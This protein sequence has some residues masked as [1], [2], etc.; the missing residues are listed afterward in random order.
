M[1]S[2]YQMALAMMEMQTEIMAEKPKY[3]MDF[4]EC[5]AN[6]YKYDYEEKLMIFAQKP[7]ATACASLE[8]WN[9]LGRWVNRGAKGI[10]LLDDRN[11]RYRLRYV[12]DVSD[13]NSRYGYEIHLWQMQQNYEQSVIGAMEN[14]FGE[15][16]RTE[17]TEVALLELSD[18]V[19][20]DNLTDYFD[21]IEALSPGIFDDENVKNE[22]TNLVVNS[23]TYMVWKRCG[24]D[25]SKIFTED[26]FENSI[27]HLNKQTLSVIGEASSDISRTILLEIGEAV[28]EAARDEAQNRTFEKEK[29]IDD[30]I[31][32]KYNSERRIEHGT[33]LQ[34]G[35]RDSNPGYGSTGESENREVRNDEVPLPPREQTPDVHNDDDRGQA[36]RASGTDRPGSDRDDGT[37][38]EADGGERGSDRNAESDGSDEV[39]TDDELDPQFGGGNGTERTDPE[40]KTELPGC[41]PDVLIQAL[42]HGDYLAESKENIVSFLSS[43]TSE[44]RKNEYVRGLYKEGLFAE[45]FKPNS[46]EHIGY[47]ATRDGLTIY[48]GNYLTRTAESF[49]SWNTTRELIEALI[50]DRNYL[51][52]PKT[53]SQISIFENAPAEKETQSV[54]QEAG[55][56]S[57][58]VLDNLLR[59]GSATPNST[60]R[61]YGYY[62][63]P[64]TEAENIVFLLEEYESD[65]IGFEVNGKKYAAVWNESGVDIAEGNSVAESASKVHYEWETIEARIRELIES[66]QYISSSEAEKAADVWDDHVADKITSLHWDYF[67]NIPDEYLMLTGHAG[68]FP[69]QKDFY[70]G[71]LRHPHRKTELLEEIRANIGRISE[72]PPRFKYNFSPEYVEMLT[73]SYLKEPKTYPAGNVLPPAYYVSQ[74]KVDEYFIGDKNYLNETKLGIYSFFLNE[75][76]AGKRAKF[77]SERYGIGGSGGHRYNTE[78]DGKGLRIGGGLEGFRQGEMLKWS[79]VAK[80]IE[81]LIKADRFLNDKEKAY[82]DTYEKKQVARCIQHF[83]IDKPDDVPKPYQGTFVDDHTKEIIPQM[84]DADRFAEIRNIMISAFEA[85]TPDDRHYLSDKENLETVRRYADGE[86]DLFPG[87]PYRAKET[88]SP[89]AEN[90][91]AEEKTVP[92]EPN[93]GLQNDYDIH[94]GTEVYIGDR[95]YVVDS[96]EDTVELDDGTLF[97]EFMDKETFY[98]RISENPLNDRLKI[99]RNET[100]EVGDRQV[101]I[102]PTVETEHLSDNTVDHVYIDTDE[103]QVRWMYYNPDSSQGGEYVISRLDFRNFIDAYENTLEDS[104]PD[105]PKAFDAFMDSISDMADVEYSTV[106][107]PDF[108]LADSDY[109]VKPDYIGMDTK[110]V[111]AIYEKLYSLTTDLEAQRESDAYEAEFGADGYRVFPG[112]RPKD[113]IDVLYAVLSKLKIDDVVLSYDGNGL[114]AKDNDNEWHGKEFY[115]FL[116]NE[117]FV[118]EDDGTVLGLSDNLLSDFTEQA[119]KYGIKVRDNRL[120][121]LWLDYSE[122]KAE[123]PDHILFYRVGDFYEVFGDDAETAAGALDLILTHRNIGLDKQVP[124]CGVPFHV[125]DSY[126]EKLVQA[127]CRVAV[128]EE[129]DGKN[130]T[131]KIGTEITEDLLKEK[132][133][134]NIPEISIAPPPPTR[135]GKIVPNVIYPEIHSDERKNFHIQ[136]D[137]VGEGTPT[138]RFYHNIH[139]I[140]L[141]KKLED[142]HRLANDLEQDILSDYVGWGGLPQFFE[143]DNPHYE[144]LKN[145]LTEEEYA[146]ARESSLTAFYTPPVVIKAMY[147]ALENMG[148]R[149]GNLLE[150]SCGVGNFIGLVPDSMKNSQMFG[151]ELDSISGR[152]AQQLYQSTS[153][154]VQ[155]FEKTELPDNFFDVAIGNVPFGNYKIPDKRYDK[156]NFLIHDYFF[157]RTLDKVRPGG[158]VAFITSKGTMDKANPAVRKYIAQRADL[159]GAIRLPNDTFKAAAGTEVTSDILFLQK[160]DGLLDIEPDWVHL[161]KDENGLVMNQYFIDNPDM[162]LGEMKEVSGQFGPETACV[163]YEDQSLE[164]LLRGAIQNINGSI[165]EYEADDPDITEDDTIPADPSVRNFSFTI[166]DD[167]IFYRENSIMRPMELSAT[168]ESRVKGLVA[169]RDSVRRLIELQTED[170]IVLRIL[171][172]LPELVTQLLRKLKIMYD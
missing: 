138:E 162:I 17:Y 18:H 77:M 109:S 118:F 39:G 87:T 159:I 88:T 121:P 80:R 29:K 6:N 8:T 103:K 64:G 65:C 117:A 127:G 128:A 172:K 168:G 110:T 160:R 90:E 9:K 43:E 136:N 123:Y 62:L 7:Y 158:I 112:N 19:V 61:I 82:L 132:A 116:V 41:M 35:G 28:K 91:T 1:Q 47:H 67:E 71:M 167:R 104:S 75:K 49:F 79:Q 52:V 13:T 100:V 57:A 33:E 48:D 27:R 119:E 4:L 95:E 89:K 51:D 106:K 131:R 170:L 120:N 45:M 73:R 152:I 156:N 68:G 122:L 55:I 20:K 66:G 140:E 157:A 26:V 165:M 102:N 129:Q 78:H 134:T 24:Y 42:R 111:S 74:D 46:T 97:H 11:P 163:P 37:P 145:L 125:L 40:L 114:V 69:S 108:F 58:E 99:Q 124:M 63:R 31:G 92:Q 84:E 59:L 23:V 38:H 94:L 10:V 133:E 83:F 139:A 44:D 76:D 130:I 146:S 126:V 143:E 30:N 164:D 36:E 50:E 135:N 21:H 149:S 141:I 70:R 153:V 93:N 12:F 3:Y 107:T 15:L 150:P 148:F 151:V 54:K 154:A 60:A 113:E 85:E 56:A 105:D 142:E 161:G 34:A 101:I 169:I 22:V 14:H 144:E 2:K 5:A 32:E 166:V 72:Y 96:L 171:R 137:H 53:A 115:A 16:T 86:Y 155:G 81:Q 25:T 98:R 147:Q